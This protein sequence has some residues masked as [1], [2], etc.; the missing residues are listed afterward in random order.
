MSTNNKNRNLIVIAEDSRTQAEKLKFLLNGFGYEVAHGI[1]G[2]EAFNLA[3]KYLPI[4][5]ITDI[6][7]PEMNGYELCRKIK[8]DE[9]LRQIPVVLLTLLKDSTDILNSL[10]CGADNYIMKP[11]DEKYLL[12]HLQSII[13]NKHILKEDQLKTT[14]DISFS[15][16][17]YSIS[18]TR[19][20]ILGMLLSTYQGAVRK[21]REL[22]ST[23]EELN[24]LNNTLEQK[25][26][27]KTRDLLIEVDAQKQIE[28]AIKES[29]FKYRNLIENALVGV[30]STTVEGEFTFVNEALVNMLEYPSMLEFIPR[31]IQSLFTNKKVYITF[32][33]ELKKNHQVRNFEAEFTSGTGKEIIVII[34]AQ[35]KGKTLSGMIADITDRKED[36]EKER[37]YRE[38]LFT[39]K[40]KAE[41]SYRLKSTFL[42][43]MSHEIRTPIN[44]ITGFAGLIADHDLPNEQKKEFINNISKSSVNLLNII[45][46]I[47][48]IAKLEAKKIKIISEKC[49]LNRTLTDIY[50]SFHKE[51]N[52]KGKESIEFKL[53]TANKDKD[54]AVLTDPF[55][56]KQI[57]S[58]L[59]NN[60]FKF[61]H[62]GSIEFGY[63]FASDRGKDKNGKEIEFYVKDTGIGLSEDQKKYIFERFRKV[64]NE[65]VKIYE[66]TGLG[67][68]ISKKIVSLLDGDIWVE[69]EIGKGSTFYFT[70]PLQVF[71]KP[72]KEIIKKIAPTER[73]SIN[74]RKI[75]IAEDNELN[76]LLLKAI[77]TGAGAEILW[78][79]DGVEAVECCVENDDIEVVLMDIRMPNMD[80]YQATKEIKKIRKS[81][82]V[83]AVT[84]YSMN[85]EQIKSQELEFDDFLTKPVKPDMLMDTISKQLRKKMEEV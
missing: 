2:K 76:Y 77:L 72:F 21:T 42:Q 85:D 63:N 18:L 52:K 38:R 43:N 61:T 82:P 81:L 31:N 14:I 62:R 45:D 39:A 80:G 40:E 74:G 1:N 41:E 68:A 48:L 29:E 78:A 9:K 8:A 23:Q 10:E 20:Q 83:I 7:M 33:D 47:L 71:E 58:N 79:K 24:T 15:N 6:I 44:V 32:I 34:N 22:I 64:E 36:E 30:F 16:K 55:R 11:Y 13:A 66:G 5:I 56:L 25:I 46:N 54:L 4:M 69:S 35:L 49:F 50:T 60:A 37:K 84:A 12:T 59:L 53:K 3:K 67:L 73:I 70:I 28:E 19:L 65:K 27:E 17:E 75:L 57:I 26:K 51:K